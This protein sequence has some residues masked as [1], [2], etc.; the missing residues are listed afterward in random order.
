MRWALVHQVWTSRDK[1]LLQRVSD[2]LH[3]DAGTEKQLLVQC[4][5]RR[6][7]SSLGIGSLSLLPDDL[8][9]HPRD[10]YDSLGVKKGQCCALRSTMNT[11]E[12]RLSNVKCELFSGS[13]VIGRSILRDKASF[14]T[15]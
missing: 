11:N 2:E 14:K 10:L 4:S 9:S 6:A 3:T 5:R 1:C 7:R 13:V 12:R 8:L 15:P